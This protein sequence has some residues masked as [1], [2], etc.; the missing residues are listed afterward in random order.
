MGP[1]VPE[2]QT[3]NRPRG[4]SFN[5]PYIFSVTAFCHEPDQWLF[6]GIWRVRDRRPDRYVVELTG[7]G[8]GFVGR[9]KLPSS[10]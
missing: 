3:V 10:S 1:T 6:G 4:N 2:R 8:A 9:L 5:R 7:Q